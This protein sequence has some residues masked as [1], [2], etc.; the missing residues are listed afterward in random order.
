MVWSQL[1]DIADTGDFVL[2]VCLSVAGAIG[3]AVGVLMT[4]TT[5][6]R[7]PDLDMV[8]LTAGQ[9]LSAAQPPS[10]IAF[11]ISGSGSD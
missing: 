6:T 3:W 11:A 7:Q 5:F 9:Y 10:S 4:K 2:G 8:G 1:G